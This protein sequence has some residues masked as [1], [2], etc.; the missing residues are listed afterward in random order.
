MKKSKTFSARS[1][2]DLQ[3]QVDNFEDM[4]NI[5]PTGHIVSVSDIVHITSGWVS[6]TIVYVGNI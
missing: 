2:E 3:I 6:V 5:H 1:M 4:I